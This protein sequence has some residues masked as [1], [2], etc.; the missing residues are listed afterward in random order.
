MGQKRK[1]ANPDVMFDLSRMLVP[2]DLLA[3]FEI[4]EVKELYKE[5]HIVLHEKPDQIPG[6]LSGFS[7]V[8][9]DGFCNPLNVLSHG[10]ST[11]P[12]YLIIKRRR[13]KRSGTDEH[14]SNQYTI[15]E[16]S[17]KVAPGMAGFLKI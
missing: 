12:V 6:K 16:D 13:W 9:L 3:F 1:A 8:V 17:S 14:F 15:T 7:D 2:A 4:A 5:W 11:K 10:F